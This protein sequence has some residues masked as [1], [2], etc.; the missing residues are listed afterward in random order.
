MAVAVGNWENDSQCYEVNLDEQNHT[1]NNGS[2]IEYGEEYQSKLSNEFRLYGPIG[3]ET[4][5]EPSTYNSDSEQRLVWH[6]RLSD[7]SM[8]RLQRMAT[9]GDLPKGLATCKVPIC[10]SFYLW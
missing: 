2:V 6:Q 7:V 3:V 10:Q 4:L 5:K 1:E 9:H 8:A